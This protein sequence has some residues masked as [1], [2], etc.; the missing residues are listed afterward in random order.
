[1]TVTPT[2][3]FLYINEGDPL[4]IFAFIYNGWIA[5]DAGDNG[6]TVL[7]NT[8]GASYDQSSSTSAG[9]YTVTPTPSNSNYSYT[10]ETGTLHVNPYGPGTRAV[11]PVLNCIQ[12][13]DTDYFVANF[14]YRNNNNAAVYVPLGVDNFLTGTGIDW[15]SSDSI[16]TMFA[17]GGGSFRVFFDGSSLSWTVNSRDGNQK[18]SNAANANSSSTKCNGNT[19][20]ASIASEVSTIN[21]LDP[22]QLTAYPNPVQDKVYLSLK[23]IENYKMI[24]LFDFAGRSFPITSID[25][26]TDVLELD[27]ADVP[28][29]HY[30]VSVVMEDSTR[31]VQ[32]IKH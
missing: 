27:M 17:P 25:K 13:I 1:M 28:A 12:E 23:G 9:T 26:R 14:E 11:K 32:L 15:E 4:P 10:F 31:V 22:D 8:D 2:E 7:R 5:G 21:E 16:P 30:V 20:G 19:K 3:S 18:V 29:G 24:K 6:Y